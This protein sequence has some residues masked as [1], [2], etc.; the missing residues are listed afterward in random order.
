MF[1]GL[2]LINSCNSKAFKVLNYLK[3]HVLLF[4][5]VL[6]Q[7]YVSTSVCSFSVVFS[8][9]LPCLCEVLF[10]FFI[11]VGVLSWSVKTFRSQSLVHWGLHLGYKDVVL[12]ESC[13]MSWV[14]EEICHTF[15][16]YFKTTNVLGFVFIVWCWSDNVAEQCWLF[17]PPLDLLGFDLFRSCF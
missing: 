11:M 10:G 9:L 14:Q 8:W 12:V 17:S 2:F 6:P 4:P 15:N 1:S 3:A 13:S 16:Y 5:T 7:T